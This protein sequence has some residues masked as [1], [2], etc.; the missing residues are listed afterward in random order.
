MAGEKAKATQLIIKAIETQSQ[1]LITK[2]H[3][4]QI[5]IVKTQLADYKKDLE[6]HFS[7]LL[8]QDKEQFQDQLKQAS[9]LQRYHIQQNV[10]RFRQS[11]LDAYN[12]SLKD[13]ISAFK[14][15][16][17]Y[18][19]YLKEIIHDLLEDGENA[20]IYLDASDLD[21]IQDERVQERNLPLG[22]LIIEKDRQVYDYSFEEQLSKV[23][24]DF[25]KNSKLQVKGDH[26]E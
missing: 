7:S 4:Q 14:E 17:D 2:E 3:D 26:D 10:L 25:Q 18:I 8:N 9:S 13:K 23:L 24:E 1:A 6:K 11:L 16:P 20:I 15:S 19:N 21:K 22:G 12:A 5:D